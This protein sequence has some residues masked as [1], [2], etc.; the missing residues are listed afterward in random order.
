MEFPS[1]RGIAYCSDGCRSEAGREQSRQRDKK[2]R[3]NVVCAGGCG[4]LL[5]NSSTSLPPGQAT[6]Q[7]CRRARKGVVDTPR[8]THCAHCATPI[9]SKR[10]STGKWITACSLSCAAHIRLADGNHPWSDRPPAMDDAAR[11]DMWSK[12]NHRRRAIK[13]S[14][15]TEPYS[16]AEIAERDGNRCGLCRRKVR[17][18]VPFPKVGSPT[19]DHIIPLA[20][21]GDDTRRNVQLAHLGCNSSKRTRAMG[22]QLRLVG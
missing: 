11:R 18:D 21:G 4:A 5:W 12:K 20:K 2:K 15:A 19:I 1:L 9:E 22:E 10:K 17:M 7:A 8:P 13:R 3:L 6:C 16:L 14:V